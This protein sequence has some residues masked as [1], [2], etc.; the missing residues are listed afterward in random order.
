MSFEITHWENPFTPTQKRQIQT[1]IDSIFGETDISEMEHRLN[2][3]ENWIYA[4]AQDNDIHIGYKLAYLTDTKCLYSWLGGVLVDYRRL[5]IANQLMEYLINY[6]NSNG[7]EKIQ[8][9]TRLENLPMQRLNE[10]HGFS[11]IDQYIGKS[12]YEKIVYEL[13]L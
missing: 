5:G 12:G 2:K 4:F 6:A 1:M 13:V 3:Y 8:T 7:I 11:R 9:K 10:N